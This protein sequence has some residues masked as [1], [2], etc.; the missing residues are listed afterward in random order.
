MRPNPQ[1]LHALLQRR[2]AA[3]TQGCVEQTGV[4]QSPHGHEAL[5]A[6]ED[7]HPEVPPPVWPRGAGPAPQ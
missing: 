3:H 2:C 1:V 7:H 5:V 4:R 6:P